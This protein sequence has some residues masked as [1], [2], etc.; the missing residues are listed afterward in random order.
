MGKTRTRLKE[1]KRD[2]FIY[3]YQE[4]TEVTFRFDPEQNLLGT[5]T[6]SHSIFDIKHTHPWYSV[7][8]CVFDVNGGTRFGLPV[9]Q[10]KLCLL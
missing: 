1:S 8:V 4:K 7:C 3:L 5:H 9:G 2:T 6:I 10:I